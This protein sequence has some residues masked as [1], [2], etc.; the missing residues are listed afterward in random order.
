MTRSAQ[1]ALVL[2]CLLA[3]VVFNVR[4]DWKM[5]MAGHAFV[6]AQLEQRQRG[7]RVPTINDAF[8]PKVREAAL[9]A[10]QWLVLIASAGA[11]L[12]FI[13]GKRAHPRAT[14]H[15]G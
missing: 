1:V 10:G 9:E 13:A 11:V 8:R 14:R 6:A 5:R 2:W 7:M 3:I 15:G 4:F 12:T